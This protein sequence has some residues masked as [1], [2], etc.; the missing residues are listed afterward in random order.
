MYSVRPH[1]FTGYLIMHAGPV[2][3][4]RKVRKGFLL[5][6]FL[7]FFSYAYDEFGF[8]P[9]RNCH[10]ASGKS[11]ALGWLVNNMLL[12]SFD[13]DLHKSFVRACLVS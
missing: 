13:Q 9:S 11:A 10:L 12:L 5:I 7:G 8:G 1:L 4:G 2:K 3:R 6:L